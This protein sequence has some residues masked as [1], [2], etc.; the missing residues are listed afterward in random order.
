MRFECHVGGIGCSIATV[1]A[2]FT[3]NCVNFLFL[4]AVDIGDHIDVFPVIEG[5]HLSK[6]C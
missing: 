1:F 3:L 6:I 5:E 2:Y 4:F